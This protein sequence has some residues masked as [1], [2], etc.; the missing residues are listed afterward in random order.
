MNGF[1][2]RQIGGIVG[3]LY[4][5]GMASAQTAGNALE[6]FQFNPFT[7]PPEV[8]FRFRRPPLL[9]SSEPNEKERVLTWT[10]PD[11]TNEATKSKYFRFFSAPSPLES[12]EVSELEEENTPSLVVKFGLRQGYRARIFS[13]GTIVK[14]TFVKEESTAPS[15]SAGISDS[16]ETSPSLEN[17]PPTEKESSWDEWIG[18]FFVP[19]LLIGGGVLVLV[20]A[21]VGGGFVMVWSWASLRGVL[22]RRRAISSRKVFETAREMNRILER[23]RSDSEETLQEVVERQRKT[24]EALRGDL[25]TVRQAISTLIAEF[26]KTTQNVL[27]M[28][29]VASSL[30][31]PSPANAEERRRSVREWIARVSARATEEGVGGTQA[32]PLVERLE[33]LKAESN[34]VSASSEEPET[35]FALPEETHL[36]DKAR[37]A[38][39]SGVLPLE[40]AQRTGLSLG[41]VELI[42]RL[43]RLR[44]TPVNS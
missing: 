42:A 39:A 19:I 11:T 6:D 35:E 4:L 16:P 28:E 38:L 10:C 44:K 43:E 29:P 9:R 21:L 13:Q 31:T 7:N 34:P 20:G 37:A 27:L 3:G 2:F 5:V 8:Q 23:F 41:E 33:V 32:E 36:Y 15:P 30:E 1:F 14:A 22:E 40:V 25:S 17:S 18:H 24:L 12:L 26:E